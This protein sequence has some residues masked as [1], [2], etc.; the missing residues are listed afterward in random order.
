[1]G[2]G[3]ILFIDYE[4]VQLIDIESVKIF[5]K[6]IIILGDNQKNIPYELIEK[7]QKISEEFNMIK[8]NGV[9][10]NAL[11]FFIAYYLGVFIAKN[12]YDQYCI[13][14]NDKGY[15]PL[16]KHLSNHGVNIDRVQSVNKVIKPTSTKRAVKSETKKKIDN[17]QKIEENLKNL[18]EKLRP[19]NKKKLNGHIKTV[20]GNNVTDDEIELIINTL[21]SNEILIETENKINYT[22]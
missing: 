16:I 3:S 17:Y 18:D 12:E 6:I 22:C 11:D 21:V 19:K 9:G 7:I 10:K 14:S 20:L 15:D 13:Y 1:M 2:L 8:V 4:N 5:K